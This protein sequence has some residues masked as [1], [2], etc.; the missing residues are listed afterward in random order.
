[1][2]GDPHII[3]FKDEHFDF[4]GEHG[5]CYNVICSSNFLLNV[6]M[7]DT[8]GGFTIM[9]EAGIVI[10]NPENGFLK[11]SV[12]A[13]DNSISYVILKSHNDQE[14][15]VK[16][17]VKEKFKTGLIDKR[18]KKVGGFIKASH[19]DVIV[20]AGDFYVYIVR[21]TNKKHVEKGP[22]HLDLY[23]NVQRNGV[24]TQGIWPHGIVGQSLN[25]DNTKFLEG[26]EEDYLVSDLFSHDFKFDC[27]NKSDAKNIKYGVG[28]DR[29]SISV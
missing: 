5:K 12:S 24:L 23:A 7:F 22:P 10:G 28:V 21:C 1:M 14:K 27:F 13:K 18:S 9:T 19:K 3:N 11:Y 2:V 17:E 15:I 20:D 26:E 16:C 6:R 25:P 4:M 8:G 29:K